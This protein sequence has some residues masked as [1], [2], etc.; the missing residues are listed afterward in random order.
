MRLVVLATLALAATVGAGCGRTGGAPIRYEVLEDPSGLL[1][2]DEVSRAPLERDFRPAEDLALNLGLTS[3]TWWLRFQLEPSR[4]PG[5]GA[6]L[7]ELGWPLVDVAVLYARDATGHFS[8]QRAGRRVPIS[9]WPIPYRLPTFRI[10]PADD[11]THYLQVSGRET[12]ILPLSLWSESAF[13]AA[14]VRESGLLGFYF[15]MLVVMAASGLLVYVFLRDVGFLSYAGLIGTYALWQASFEG[16][17][18]TYLWPDN[19]WWIARALHVFGILTVLSGWIFARTFLSTRTLAP[20]LDRAFRR[21]APLF[22]VLLA[23]ALVAPGRAF[24]FTATFAAMFVGVWVIVAGGV[25]ARRGSRSARYFLAAW[26]FAVVAALAQA[27]RD[28]G[29]AENN[30]L[31]GY[32]L[33]I[34]IAFT[35]MTLSLGLIDRILGMRD[36]LDRTEDDVRRLEREDAA[37][38][39]F[40][41]TASH[42]LRQPLHAVG[43]LL[44]AL[45]DRLVEREAVDLVAKIQAATGEMADMF[46]GLL[47]ISRLDAGVV[48]PSVSVVDLDE[49]FARLDAEFGVLARQKGLCFEARPGGLAV[50]TDPVLLSRVLRNLLSNALRYTASGDVVLEA[51]RAVSKGDLVEIRVVD[52]GRGIPAGDQAAVF[53]A[54]RRLDGASEA[55]PAGLGLGLSIVRR[56]AGLLG[57]PL[58]MESV[59]GQGTTFTLELPAGERIATAAGAGSDAPGR[60]DGLSVLVV[61]DD[62]AVRDGMRLQLESWGCAV[63]VAGT[64]EEACAIDPSAALD[65]VLADYHV[66]PGAN[67]IEIVQEIRRRAGREVAA[68]LITGDSSDLPAGRAEEYGLRVL[69]KPV[70][71]ARLRTILN[72]I[73]RKR[74]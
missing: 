2:V 63:R 47:D 32:G 24:V 48:E 16:L 12:L 60:L 68:I 14:R 22:G 57:H 45:R 72:R 49:A 29:F 66:G 56:L 58:R 43:L 53:D 38:R 20:S 10:D 33:Q 25:V 70:P 36:D 59:A 62:A 73:A 4:F 41:A 51:R 55:A 19:A 3:S 30:P 69:T 21:G 67:G 26:V 65:L 7:L 44:G 27:L 17:F 71:P 5:G 35:F 61:E 46:N 31:T 15:G 28:L 1:T 11:A 37:K 50:R 74:A 39:S 54:Y 13:A 34:G 23:W 64:P 18:S 42:D 6:P 8:T 9:A 52:T 40:L